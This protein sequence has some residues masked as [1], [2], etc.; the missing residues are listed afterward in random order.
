M[1]MTTQSQ[2]PSRHGRQNLRSAMKGTRFKR[3]C[4][5]LPINGF[6]LA[7]RRGGG[8]LAGQES[9]GKTKSVILGC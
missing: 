4:S 9:C 8:C 5:G 3:S 2:E 1:M 6:G 7:M